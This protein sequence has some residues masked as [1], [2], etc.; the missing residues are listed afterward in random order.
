V[1]VEL[2]VV[3]EF[4]YLHDN[5]ETRSHHQLVVDLLEVH[6]YDLLVIHNYERVV[7]LHN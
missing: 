3:E 4:N 1:I 6:D 7:H 2:V 5:F